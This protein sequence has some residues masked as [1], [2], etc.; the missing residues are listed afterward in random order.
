[1]HAD[2]VNDTTL[3]SASAENDPYPV[4]VRSWS[5]RASD[6]L[7]G[8]DYFISYR[9]SDGRAYA[10]KLAAR[11]K[12]ENYDCFLDSDGFLKGDDWRQV[13]DRE[14]RK[15]AR[16]VLI[17]SPEVHLS[18]PVVRELTVFSKRGK[19]LIAIEFGDSLT[20]ATHPDS[21]VLKILGN[22]IVRE[23]EPLEALGEGPSD[24]VI[25]ELR[26]T[27]RGETTAK[28]R[29]RAI[30][31][32]AAVLLLL[33]VAVAVAGILAE[34]QYQRNVMNS[35]HEDAVRGGALASERRGAEAVCYLARS[36][37]RNA[38]DAF[39][40]SALLR[41]AHE[42]PPDHPALI[43]AAQSE[44]LELNDEG[45]VALLLEKGGKA[46][47]WRQGAAGVTELRTGQ[48]NTKVAL[49]P[50]GAHALVAAGKQWKRCDLKESSEGRWLEASASITALA[51]SDTGAAGIGMEDGDVAIQETPGA[52]VEKIGS[53]PAAIEEIRLLKAPLLIAASDTKH[54]AKVWHSKRER[55][56]LEALNDA[57]D[58]SFFSGVALSD[59][60]TFWTAESTQDDNAMQE[61]WTDFTSYNFENGANSGAAPRVRDGSTL[62]DC[63]TSANG[64]CC[65]ARFSSQRLFSFGAQTTERI[66][67]GLSACALSRDGQIV[68]TA[69]NTG[70]V[71]RWHA[72][73]LQPIG[74]SFS[75]HEIRALRANRPGSRVLATGRD[76]TYLLQFASAA[77]TQLRTA[78]SWMEVP[79]LPLGFVRVADRWSDVEKTGEDFRPALSGGDGEWAF[80]QGGRT[81]HFS[82]I[83]S[84]EENGEAEERHSRFLN[85]ITFHP[86]VIPETHAIAALDHRTVLTSAGGQPVRVWDGKTGKLIRELVPPPAD[87]ETRWW[88]DELSIS[89]KG[90]RALV[91]WIDAGNRDTHRY[92]LYEVATGKPVGSAK[93]VGLN[94]DVWALTP[95]LSGVLESV[96]NELTLIDAASNNVRVGPL[97]LT[98]PCWKA[99]FDP[100]G[101]VIIALTRKG[102]FRIW[103]ASDG[104]PLSGMLSFDPE[105]V[106]VSDEQRNMD[107]YRVSIWVAPSRQNDA[108]PTQIAFLI[109]N[110]NTEKPPIRLF[111]VFELGVNCSAKDRETFGML[112]A[113]VYGA[114]LTEDGLV[115]R[116]PVPPTAQ[117]ERKFTR[118]KSWD[119]PAMKA[120]AERMIAGSIR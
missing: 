36:L 107:A 56:P 26:R 101:Q 48:V 84:A 13:G 119:E 39:V 71:N 11:L 46:K 21:P 115:I 62:I 63:Q 98:D 88:V 82:Q 100:S 64:E 58:G 67:T 120:L 108:P 86:V 37:H 51:I 43:D 34:W 53:M 9:W 23:K 42:Q 32:T 78:G 95:D 50:S 60:G 104:M 106:P 31:V 35:A 27:F 105:A 18:E 90:D 8:R 117:L 28:R 17:G 15:T 77:R 93:I 76:G 70:A 47:V 45:N 73:G 68:I 3:R 6:W 41:L 87:D 94:E 22:D 59:L 66:F 83:F 4:E 116:K 54:Q 44:Q 72:Q 38:S 81:M 89:A 118:E 97:T 29:M 2:D 7:F 61:R 65:L 52:N 19:R 110:D 103:R 55:S 33:L 12:A 109:E 75:P 85:E 49:S 113:E 92:Q 91:R 10:A 99:A 74:S 16:L 102:E 1:M 111:R 69:R 24:K 20:L 5:Q 79:E 80:E 25:N 114:A 96:D 14:L 40:F 30:K 112:S 57:N